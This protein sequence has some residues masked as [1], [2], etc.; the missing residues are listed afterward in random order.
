V[1]IEPTIPVFE[2]AK[3][4][5]A[6]DRAVTLIGSSTELTGYLNPRHQRVKMA[7]MSEEEKEIALIL[8]IRKCDDIN[9]DDALEGIF[10]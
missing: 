4:V 5:H 10:R 3:T 1:G 8:S 7:V 2:R 6:L 9:C